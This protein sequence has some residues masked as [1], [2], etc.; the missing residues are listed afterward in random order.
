MT[1][2]ESSRLYESGLQFRTESRSSPKEWLCAYGSQNDER[3]ESRR[4]YVTCPVCSGELIQDRSKEQSHRSL[5]LNVVSCSTTQTGCSLTPGFSS[6]YMVFRPSVL[7]RIP[8][9]Q[10]DFSSGRRSTPTFCLEF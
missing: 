4:R 6:A 3:M 1:S 2:D 9:S 10:V 7:P 5:V 8:E